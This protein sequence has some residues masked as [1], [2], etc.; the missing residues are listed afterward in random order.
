MAV[1]PGRR[2][3]RALA[4]RILSL[5]PPPRDAAAASLARS[6]VS[7]VRGTPLRRATASPGGPADRDRRYFQARLAEEAGDLGRALEIVEDLLAQGPDDL[8]ALRL[9]RR[10]LAAGG[11]TAR[12]LLAL[13]AEQSVRDSLELS[14]L[15]RWAQGCLAISDPRWEPSLERPRPP[16]GRRLVPDGVLHLLASDPAELADPGHRLR[17]RIAEDVAAGRH[18][19]VLV[20]PP[21]GADAGHPSIAPLGGIAPV[22]VALPLDAFDAPDAAVVDLVWRAERLATE[23]QLARINV[24]V[25]PSAVELGVAALALGRRSGARVVVVVDEEP[26]IA[27]S[28]PPAG[29]TDANGWRS[30]LLADIARRADASAGATAGGTGS[31]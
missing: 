26:P 24:D 11:P 15:E 23:V 18:A 7:L 17:S 4:A 2:R 1:P 20:V 19:V 21:A 31:P 8:A 12:L 3:G 29:A 22:R 25:S 13:A 5:L 6:A 30:A 9:R 10:V 27:L 14:L 28:R 16:A